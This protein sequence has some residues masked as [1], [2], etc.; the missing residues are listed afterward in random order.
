VDDF[1]NTLPGH[2]TGR[3]PRAAGLFDDEIQRNGGEAEMESL[4]LTEGFNGWSAAG[5]AF[6]KYTTKN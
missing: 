2:S 6:D 5:G 3:G 1:T 4:V